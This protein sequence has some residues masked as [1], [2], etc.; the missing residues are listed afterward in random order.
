MELNRNSLSA[1][2]YRF[3][4]GHD[5]MPTNLC[6]Y[7]WKLVLIYMS[8][9]PLTILA[10]PS[11]VMVKLTNS[12]KYSTKWTPLVTLARGGFIIYLSIYVV[13]AMLFALGAFIF[14]YNYIPEENEVLSFLAFTQVL[15]LVLVYSVV[16]S[17]IIWLTVYTITTIVKSSDADRWKS[18][19]SNIIIQFV[20]AKYN[21]YC[22]QIQWKH[23]KE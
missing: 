23:T 11:M 16:L 17:T 7:F 12:H 10:L 2:L 6:P 1:R 5:K 13:L 3:Y 20:K 9:I 14:D 22:P 4:V 15:G 19:D 21:R 8:V 18:R